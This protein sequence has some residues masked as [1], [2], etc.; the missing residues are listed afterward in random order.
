MRR[1]AALLVCLCLLVSLCLAACGDD[2][3]G[4]SNGLYVP[5]KDSSGNITG[6]ERRYYNDNGDIT[7]WDVYDSNEVYD[8]Y[9]LYEYDSSNRLIQETTYRAD[10]IGDFYYTYLY[11]DDDVVIEK[12]YYTMKDGAQVTLYSDDGTES[13]RYTYDN[14]DTLT[15]YEV[16]ENGTWTEAPIPTESETEAE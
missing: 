9:V 11:N 13:E 5:V 7:R 2:D 16:Y 15:L 8:H 3:S 10:G 4:D 1:L 12:G 6:Y 14:T